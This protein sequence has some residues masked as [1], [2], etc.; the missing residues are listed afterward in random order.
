MDHSPCPTVLFVFH[1]NLF[2]IHL[3]CPTIFQFRKADRATQS[4]WVT[5]LWA[6]ARLLVDK[7]CGLEWSPASHASCLLLFLVYWYHET[8]FEKSVLLAEISMKNQLSAVVETILATG[9]EKNRP[10]VG[11]SRGNFGF[12]AKFRRK[13]GHGA[14][15]A[16]KGGLKK[17]PK[18][19]QFFWIYRRFFQK[20][21]WKFFF[22]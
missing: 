18:N 17:K 10:N 7:M 15:R 11:E 8:R 21:Q 6:L 16:V 20:N 4:L 1:G 2:F 22:K 5:I 19:R 3:Y 12:G 13:M 9:R 14:M